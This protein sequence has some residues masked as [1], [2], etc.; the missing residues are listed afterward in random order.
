MRA[1]WQKIVCLLGMFLG[2]LSCSKVPDGILSEKE[3]QRVLKDMLLAESMIGVDYE[4]FKTDTSKVALY[5]AVFRKHGIDQALY[6]SSLIW[7]GKNLDIYIK[8]YDRV[9]ADLK[10]QITDLGDVQADAAPSSGN[11]SVDIWPRRR[12]LT[13]TPRSL[14][15]GVTF[16]IRPDR[17]FP[18]GSSFVLGLRAWGLRPEMTRKPEIRLQA[19]LG[20]TTVVLNQTITRDGYLEARLKTI[21]TKRIRRVYGYIRLDGNERDYGKIYLDSLSVMRYNYK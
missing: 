17:P 11:D 2:C 16:T 1:G 14:F 12:Y 13:F 18:S 3:M 5:E 9:V 10:Q 8:V 20:D 21:A 7:Y 6:D 15:N 4:Q 19:D